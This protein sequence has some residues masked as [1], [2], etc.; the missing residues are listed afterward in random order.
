MADEKMWATNNFYGQRKIIL[1]KVL[2]ETLI[3]RDIYQIYLI[4]Q[5]FRH[6]VHE[7]MVCGSIMIGF[8]LVIADSEQDMP[9]I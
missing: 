7:S 3:P 4:S 9:G 5:Y 8:P 1:T 2:E 6:V